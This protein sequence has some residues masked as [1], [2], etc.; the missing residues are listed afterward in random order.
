MPTIHE[1]VFVCELCGKPQTYPVYCKSDVPVDDELI[2]SATEHLRLAHWNQEH[3]NC[4]VCGKR[5]GLQEMELAYNDESISI[6]KDYTDYHTK[7][8]L[9]DKQLLRVHPSCLNAST[10]A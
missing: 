6:H 7:V 5:I 4:A 9:G 10:R 1:V 8:K 3:L 2:Q